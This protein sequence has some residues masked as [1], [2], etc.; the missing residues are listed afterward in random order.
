MELGAGVILPSE[1]MENV[2]RYSVLTD[3]SGA[4]FGIHRRESAQPE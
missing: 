2:G 3:P 4:A 1:S